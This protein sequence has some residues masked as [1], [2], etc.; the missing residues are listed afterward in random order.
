LK[1]ETIQIPTF[2][3][4]IGDPNPTGHTLNLTTTPLILVEG[5]YLASSADP[6]HLLQTYADETWFL[7]TELDL[8]CERLALRHVATGLVKDVEEG[9]KRVR[10]NDALN[11]NWIVE[12]LNVGALSKRITLK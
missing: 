2:N 6:W 12:T 1:I 5:L 3:H 10:E 11:A 7:D 9:W 4:A 8:A